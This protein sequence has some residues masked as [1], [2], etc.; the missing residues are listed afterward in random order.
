VGYYPADA[1][2]GAKLAYAGK[3]GSGLAERDL[4]AFAD[5]FARIA[6]DESPFAVTVERGVHFVQPLV[7][8]EVRFTE[9]TDLGTMRHPVYMGVRTDKT[10]TD[11]HRD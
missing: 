10:P 7:V 3:V 1:A 8:V 5:A 2:P 11:V 6:T 4:D 9:W